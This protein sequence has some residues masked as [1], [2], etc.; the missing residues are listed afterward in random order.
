MAE[1][2]KINANNTT[3]DIKD[4][5]SR[6]AL[7]E[8]IDEGAKN[9]L[10]FDETSTDNNNVRFTVNA[11]GSI[12]ATQIAARTATAIFR[13][14]YTDN[15]L[16]QDVRGKILSGCPHGGADNTYKINIERRTSPYTNYGRDTGNGLLIPDTIADGIPLYLYIQVY[17]S[18]TLPITFKPMIC[19]A[20]D[21]AISQKFVPYRPSW[22][23]M[24]DE[25][26]TKATV[27]NIYGC[28]TAIPS[29]SN[30]NDY[31]TPG[32]YRVESSTV[33]GTISNLPTGAAA[34]RL[35]VKG[36]NAADRY[37]QIYYSGDVIFQRR[38]NGSSWF[39]WYKFEGTA[40][41]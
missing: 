35:E 38:W 21:W 39:T 23:E 3:Y 20:A 19:T 14:R 5:T 40:V 27:A 41:T 18:A 24:A 15:L 12:T 34:G 11:D 32:V 22:Q 33:A 10:W 9:L 16:S 37:L 28:G 8:V 7:A 30:L 36:L 31:K 6:A 17:S 25:I 4:S 2:S 26:A 13:M 1:I 29:N